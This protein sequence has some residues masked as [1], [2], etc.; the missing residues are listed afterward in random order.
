MNLYDKDKVKQALE[1]I[2]DGYS[3]AEQTYNN[4]INRIKGENYMEKKINIKRFAACFAVA[5][6]LLTVGVTAA[7]HYAK[8]SYSHSNINDK[9]NHA[10]T[11]AEVEMA[12]DYLP[13]YA[14]KL[15]DYTLTSAQ[16]IEGGYED[17]NHNEMSAVKEISFEYTN[18]DKRV[19]LFTSNS[20]AQFEEKGEEL[21][22]VNGISLYYI[23]T[24]NKFVP[25]DYQ[26]TAEEQAQVEA[27]TL[28]IGY[29]SDEVELVASEYLSWT[30]DGISYGL[31]TMDNNLGSDELAK[32][33]EEIINQ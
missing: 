15:G 12:V 4:I 33:A 29:G 13:K 2:T 25:P 3:P 24:I 17:E 27:G 5:A 9:I 22:K 32:M 26:P 21:S 20:P 23:Y 18:G 14:N 10:P 7:S 16:P 30:E 11:T 19:Q 1:Q 6:A 8:Y 31:M 28:N